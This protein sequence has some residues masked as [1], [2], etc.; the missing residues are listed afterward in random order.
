MIALEWSEILRPN[1]EQE[2]S[3]ELEQQLINAMGRLRS[4]RLENE[5][6]VKQSV[7][8]P[9][10]RALGWNTDDDEQVRPE[11]RVGDGW[12]DYALLHH[13]PLVFIE[14]KHIGKAEDKKSREQL[15]GYAANR[16]IPILVL[17]DGRRW[18]FY[19]SAGRGVWQDRCFHR[20][21]L[22]H[23]RK[24]HDYAKSLTE[25]LGKT[26]V[27]SG[28][29]E[30]GAIERLRA[31]QTVP[32]AWRTLLSE[33][34]PRLCNLI[35]E[36]VRAVCGANPHVDD[37][38]SFLKSATQE[39]RDVYS[40]ANSDVGAHSSE[41]SEPTHAARRKAAEEDHRKAP[42]GMKEP[43][44]SAPA[45]QVQAGSPKP[46]RGLKT[47]Q[48]AFRRPILQVLIEMGGRGE[49]R[50]VLDRL[51]EVM[52][53][54]LGDHDRES[55][56][57]GTVRWEKTAEFQCTEMR[58]IGLLKPVSRKGVWEVSDQGRSWSEQQ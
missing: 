51:A 45:P 28:N 46:R 11:Y 20:L 2:V 48:S 49:R 55:H 5:A 10:L 41:S 38:R 30:G 53:S 21:E 12:V 22:D 1:D 40:S 56:R 31:K 57:D 18:D 29:A 50:Q 24:A 9:I 35:E 54:R 17:T 19:C 7:I 43:A 44:G 27:V 23:E 33:P 52:A 26:A 16:G 4:G 32:E 25:H 14:A 3:V 15:F 8:L 47:P 42:G 39:F 13:Q 6:Q 34:H 37:V 36:Q 58:R